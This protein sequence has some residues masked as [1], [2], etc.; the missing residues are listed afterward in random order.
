M[1]R[2]LD[3]LAPAIERGVPVVGLEPSCILSLRDEALVLGLGDAARAL[4]ALAMTFEEYLARE[5]DAGGLQLPLAALD[6]EQVFLHGH[7][8]QK[9]H[10]VVRPIEKVLQLIPGLE[11]KPI[12]SGC[13]G[14]AGAF[15][16]EAEHFDASQKMAELALLPA[17]RQAGRQA[18]VAA[19]GT[20]CRHQIKDGA[21]H[22]ALH[23][24]QILAMALDAQ[25]SRVP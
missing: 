15:G 9:A 8:H 18:L 6:H 12:Q 3:A 7:C 14:M 23:V 5:H 13:C 20:S 19:D 22:N 17:A 11:V 10:D 4:S 16:Y 25:A 1:R 21:D 2:T 24:A